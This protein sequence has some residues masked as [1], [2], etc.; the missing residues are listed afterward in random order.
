MAK[1]KKIIKTTKKLS[2]GSPFTIYW[3]KENYYLL[4]L[5]V[6]ILIAGYY[7]MS[8]GPWNNPLTLV[9]SPILLVIGY[10]FVLPYAIF[11]KK[12]QNASKADVENVAGQS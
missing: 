3:G 5:G 7:V 8:I 1:A 10:L 9:L 11:Y 6:L 12:K 4:L 2:L